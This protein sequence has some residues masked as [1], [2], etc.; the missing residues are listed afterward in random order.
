VDNLADPVDIWTGLWTTGSTSAGLKGG[1]V[2]S[3][4]PGYGVQPTS[5]PTTVRHRT[6][7]CRARIGRSSTPSTPL[8]GTATGYGSL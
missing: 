4:S 1:S 8:R 6:A 2:D 7:G 5:S 3:L